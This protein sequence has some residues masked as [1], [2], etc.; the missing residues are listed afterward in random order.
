MRRRRK[1]RAGGVCK[2]GGL[3]S[4]TRGC[5]SRPAA[6]A[7]TETP[8]ARHTQTQHQLRWLYWSMTQLL[9]TR[10]I[11]LYGMVIVKYAVFLPL[12]PTPNFALLNLQGCIE[13]GIAWYRPI[14]A[15]LTVGNCVPRLMSAHRGALVTVHPPC[16]PT[17]ERWEWRWPA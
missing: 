9:W 13:Y 12:C 6:P 8:A 7:H 5:V 1:R 15:W 4:A 14:S 10:A 16:I 2:G 3:P 17:G 11:M